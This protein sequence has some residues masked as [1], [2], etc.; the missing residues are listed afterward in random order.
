MADKENTSKEGENLTQSLKQLKEIADWF[1]S[2]S[3]V[4]VEEGLKKV[5]QAATL[6]KSSK[7]RLAEIENE[8]QVIEKEIADEAEP[9]RATNEP[10]QVAE[11]EP[12][13][14]QDI[15]F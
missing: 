1:D 15:P 4:D 10:P 12:V 13:N 7:K 8:F 11:D 14:L 6:I 9:E 2:Q 5:R 3:E